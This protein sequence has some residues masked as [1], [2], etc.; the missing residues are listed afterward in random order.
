M[1]NENYDNLSDGLLW[2]IWCEHILD[3]LNSMFVTTKVITQADTHP[4]TPLQYCHEVL[5]PKV[6]ARLIQEDFDGISFKEAQK[7]MEESNAFGSHC[8]PLN[9]N[10]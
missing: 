8:Y 3:T 5:V 10:S 9:R 7:I 4:Q 2:T 1:V 6:S